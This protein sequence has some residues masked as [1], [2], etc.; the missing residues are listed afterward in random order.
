MVALKATLDTIRSVAFG[1]ITNSY[2]AL[3]TPLTHVTRLIRFINDTDT[4][5][6]IS[7]DAV[8]NM[9][10]LPAGSFILFDLTTNREA[11]GDIF[12]F[13]KGTQFYIKYNT[14][15]GARAVYIEC[16]YGDGQ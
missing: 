3:G 1:S 6:F 9:L 13:A 2:T 16:V 10:Y 7:T 11:S 8:N 4:A 12:A 5:M 15:P 14:A